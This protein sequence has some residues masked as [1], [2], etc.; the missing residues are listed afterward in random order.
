MANQINQTNQLTLFTSDADQL[1]YAKQQRNQAQQIAHA[2]VRYANTHNLK[3]NTKK[4]RDTQHTFI[5]G[6]SSI[7]GARLPPI[8][9]ICAISGRDLETIIEMG[10]PL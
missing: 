3:R 5:C 10:K 2:W 8:V 4:R 7:L 9:S 1:I 6:V